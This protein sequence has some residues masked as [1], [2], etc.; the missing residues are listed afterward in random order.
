M[1]K[2]ALLSFLALSLS[3][4]AGEVTLLRAESSLGSRYGMTWQNTKFLIKSENGTKEQRVLIVMD[5]L[6]IQANYLRALDRDNSLWQ[7]EYT[8]SNRINNQETLIQPRDLD[9]VIQSVDGNTVDTDDN[10]GAR[11]HLAKEE[12][13]LLNDGLNLILGSANLFQEGDS[14][15]FSGVINIRNLDYVKDINV[16]YTTDNWRTQNTIKANFERYYSYGYSTVISP[17][18]QGIENWIFS[19]RLP[20]GVSEIEYAISYKVNGQEYW[21]NN[22]GNNYKITK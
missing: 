14:K 11:Y 18:A 8:F 17:N 3:S 16:V 15:R 7:A 19:A 20:N 9:F 1:K 21:D 4:F 5:G 2:I 10:R 13:S 12:G 6:T 22:F